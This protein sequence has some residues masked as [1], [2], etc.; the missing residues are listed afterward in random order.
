MTLS[1]TANGV[2]QYGLAEKRC[3]DFNT[4]GSDS[5]T[6]N[7]K[8][9]A[10]FARG[11]DMV[12]SFQC[13]AMESTKESLVKQFT[14]PLVQGVIKYLYLADTGNTEKEKAE[15][16]AFAAALL[17][18]VNHYSPSAA[19]ALRSNTYILN[20]KTVPS[21][22]VAA[23]AS[24][25]ASYSAMGMS[26]AEVGGYVSNSDKSKYAYGMEPCSDSST[27]KSSQSKNRTIDSA[28]PAE[29]AVAVLV[30]LI[31]LL[32]VFLTLYFCRS[33]L[34]L[35]CGGQRKGDALLHDHHGAEM[36]RV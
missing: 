31:F 13:E 23:K 18:F 33:R 20:P 17:P 1:G 22:F 25:E 26:C 30:I 10:L 5:S 27:K 36:S 6:V 7:E 15:L 16:W 28:T 21:G 14:I 19:A 29:I 3:S 8:V 12:P 4:C 35:C 24:L 32:L 9:L 11:R 2:F 34:C